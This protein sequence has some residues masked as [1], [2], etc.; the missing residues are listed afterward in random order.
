[1]QGNEIEIV[2]LYLYIP[3]PFPSHSEVDSEFVQNTS[4]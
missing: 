1:M 2:S 3:K 4:P